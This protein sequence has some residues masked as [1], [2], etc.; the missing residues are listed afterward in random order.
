M[1][2]QGDSAIMRA[3]L[4]ERPSTTPGAH[5]INGVGRGNNNINSTS[6]RSLTA[7]VTQDIEMNSNLAVAEPVPDDEEVA[8]GVRVPDNAGTPARRSSFSAVVLDS[9]PVL[10]VSNP[11]IVPSQEEL[12]EI[13]RDLKKYY[14]QR[15]AFRVCVVCGLLA[16][17]LG[18]GLGLGLNNGGDGSE[19][20]NQVKEAKEMPDN[21]VIS[22]QGEYEGQSMGSSVA[23]TKG[24]GTILVG[25]PEFR[26]TDRTGGLTQLF[27]L[28]RTNH[29]E[30]ITDHDH[31]D[32][33]SIDVQTSKVTSGVLFSSS[34]NEET[35][36]SG[37]SVS[38]TAFGEAMAIGYSSSLHF[39]G[40]SYV[41]AFLR[42]KDKSHVQVGQ[43]L[44]GDYAK[45]GFG[46]SVSITQIFNPQPAAINGLLLLIGSLNGGYA[47]LWAA[48][49]LGEGKYGMWSR[50]DKGDIFNH[51]IEG[52]SS[53][54]V[55]SMAG[56]S[57]RRIFLGS[58][59]ENNHTGVVRTYALSKPVR[60]A[61]NSSILT[62]EIVE[63][64]VE[65]PNMFMGDNPG[66][67]FGSSISTDKQGMSCVY[68]LV[69][70]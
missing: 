53:E 70:I 9:V 63:E 26:G 8:Y 69:V 49:D 18:L 48:P 27:F 44:Y 15:L 4:G 55:V 23:M 60:S 45:D 36:H 14:W 67:L 3:A 43:T 2:L 51:K 52:V 19:G 64:E 6:D 21:F 24:A 47:Q 42:N 35:D 16:I 66:E 5:H 37:V 33:G 54:I 61:S 22:L 39:P 12:N 59:N 1:H 65:D 20:Q 17:G 32:D 68:T 40:K 56:A 31:T 50:L 62:A 29:T 10:E 41:K 46:S 34:A 58:P 13:S 30:T 7:V 11:T 25:S 38:I 28:N 57:G